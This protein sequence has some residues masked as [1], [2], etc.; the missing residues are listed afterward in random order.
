MDHLLCNCTVFW[1]SMLFCYVTGIVV[2]DLEYLNLVLNCNTPAMLQTI[3]PRV[4]KHYCV[5]HKVTFMFLRK[6]ISRWGFFIRPL[7]ET[8][9]SKISWTLQIRVEI[10]YVYKYYY[11]TTCSSLL[12]PI[13]FYHNHNS[14]SY[15]IQNCAWQHDHN[16]VVWNNKL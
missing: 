10:N 3:I 12:R 5:T 14:L 2:Y 9:I 15:V 16:N 13:S 7:S 6:R 8:A 11:Y 1:P 4:H